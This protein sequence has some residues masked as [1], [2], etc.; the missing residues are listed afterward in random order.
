MA[1]NMKRITT[2]KVSHDHQ[3][4]KHEHFPSGPVGESTWQCRRDTFI[5]I[6]E[7][8][9]AAEELSPCTITT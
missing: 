1:T 5:P 2:V 3:N 7:F 9:H 6:Q 8:T 4:E